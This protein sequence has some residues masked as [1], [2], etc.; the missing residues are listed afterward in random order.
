MY[1]EYFVFNEYLFLIVLSFC[2][3]FLSQCYCEVIQYLQVGLG[4]GGG[5]VLLI[6]EVG[7]GKMM[8][9]CVMLVVLDDKMWVGFILNLIFLDI[10]L[11]EV[12]CD[13][14]VI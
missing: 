7:M 4:E 3:L 8:V 10:E 13:E 12:I 6:G 1:K 2:Y 9:V 5:F 11:F 14:F